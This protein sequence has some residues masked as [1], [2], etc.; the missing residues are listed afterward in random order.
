MTVPSTN[1]DRSQ[2]V[3]LANP[4][5]P[6]NVAVTYQGT[7]PT[8]V[9]LAPA[10]TQPLAD[11]GLF[12]DP[13]NGA[14]ATQWTGTDALPVVAELAGKAEADG[15][16][17]TTVVGNTTGHSVLGD[18]T[19]TP[20][21]DHPS[22]GGVLDPVILLTGTT[23]S[24]DA[25]VGTTVG[26]LSIANDYTGTPVY[27]LIDSAGG[28]FAV[29]GASIEVAGALDY[30][31]AP[32]HT[33]T[34]RVTGIDPP[35]PDK[36]FTILVL[37]ATEIAGATWNP[38]DKSAN[39]VLSS[40]NLTVTGSNGAF[41][42]MGVRGTISKSTGKYYWEITI[43]EDTGFPTFFQIG[44]ANAAVPITGGIT[45]AGGLGVA[46]V[47]DGAVT[48]ST[49]GTPVATLMA[50]DE[51]DVVGLA[52]DFDNWRMWWRVNGGNWNNSGTANPATN[53][54]G[55]PLNSGSL[56]TF[57]TGV[58]YFP[59]IYQLQITAD[60]PQQT[61]ANFGATS[62]T[63]TPPAGFLNWGGGAVGMTKNI[64]T[65]YGAVADGEWATTTLNITAG[66][67]V[68]SAASA[69]WAAGDVGKS[70][71]VPTL[72]FSSA[73]HTTISAVGGGG[74]Q[75][76]LAANCPYTLTAYSAIVAWGTNNESA[77]QDFK[78]ELQGGAV[79]LTIPAGT[80]LISSR[81]FGGLF[82]GIRNITVNATGATL[83]GELWQVQASAQYEGAGHSARTASVTAGAMFVMLLTP[84]QV[85]RFVVG[86]YTLMTGFDMQNLGY[87]TNHALHEY[88]R[89]VAIDSDSGSP[90]YGRIT[91]LTPLKNSY[92]STWP[93]YAATGMDWGGPATLYAMDPRFNHT[94]IVNGLT[95]AQFNQYGVS[96][97]SLVFNDCTFEGVGQIGPHPTMA[98]AVT[99]NNCTSPG[100]SLE[101]DKLVETFTL[102]GCSW[103]GMTL[104][105]SS[106]N[107]MILDNTDI[108]FTLNG[109]PRKTV[110]RNGSMIGTLAPGPTT[111]GYAHELNVSDSVISNFA[112]PTYH[113]SG[114]E[115]RS[116]DGSGDGIQSD[117]SIED[118]IIRI[119]A[120]M[121]FNM[122]ASQ[123]AITDGVAY[124]FDPN[125]GTLKAFTIIN[126]TE[127]APGGDIL[128]A[129]NMTLD[130]WPS[131]TYS[132]TLGLWLLTHTA[133]VCTFTNATGCPEVVDLS[134]AVAAGLPLYSYSK[135]SYTGS[136]VASPYWQIYGR[137]KKIVVDVTKAHTGPAG[138][139]V[140]NL[141]LGNAL[142]N[143]AT[144]VDTAWT[145]VIDLKTAGTRT[146]DATAGTYPVNW[147]STATGASDTLPGMSAAL[148]A[149]GNYR[150]TMTDISAE[151]SGTWPEFSV[152]VICDQG[153]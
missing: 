45:G 57:P 152:E 100:S 105:S 74:T 46:L 121:R 70:I 112:A 118:G 22:S 102:A 94:C 6:T 97:L 20:N 37:D 10:P 101:V 75:V 12:A 64:V 69:I 85:S 15:T 123:W 38:S 76:T 17:V 117:F 145:P 153:L 92:L 61:I 63:N 90:T 14:V 127:S 60:P 47:G 39:L 73:F 23:V 16:E 81:N 106:I 68:L 35:A 108:A 1:L 136:V 82:D 41:T 59:I 79:T 25:A 91:F 83:C 3:T 128:V 13:L 129:T 52:V 144:F 33:I 103:S 141:S 21:E 77:F 66:T 107:E 114:H 95:V 53:T 9:G 28:K 40:G 140:A 115:I 135:R 19:E 96:G 86:D 65:D 109:T 24:E 32:T 134:N 11:P 116:G 36:V 44:V 120:S 29:D 62:Y 8:P 139:V 84:S 87:P 99:F 104:Q 78:D 56:V 146:F 72:P 80:Y 50:Y 148:W 67:S 34:A 151:A 2:S 51:G 54:E 149:P 43:V 137:I 49:D 48:V 133:P 93:T 124:L 88:L 7:P 5:P 42:V 98:R 30:E 27:S 111:Y 71:V 119:P 138:S 55:V 89:I 4:T 58:P 126:V 130:D 122:G 147:A 132:P 131:R 26:S 18:Y 110:I 125:I 142:I 150:M 113:S 143:M 31:T